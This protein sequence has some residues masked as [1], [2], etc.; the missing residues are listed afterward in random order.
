M[1][2]SDPD[3]KQYGKKKKTNNSK[4]IL[5]FEFWLDLGL[6]PNLTTSITV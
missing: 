3:T 1:H 5:P 2:N 6:S 4:T